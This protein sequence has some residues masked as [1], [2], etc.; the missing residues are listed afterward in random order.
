MK[1]GDL[2]MRIVTNGSGVDDMSVVAMKIRW[3]WAGISKA[4]MMWPRGLE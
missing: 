4:V 1:G 3:V 2:E